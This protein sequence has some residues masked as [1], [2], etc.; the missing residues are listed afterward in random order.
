MKRT[1]FVL[2]VMGALVCAQE[3]GVPKGVLET[4]GNVSNIELT[5]YLVSGL[6]NP[7][8]ATKDEVPPD[9]NSMLQ[10]LHGVFMYKNYKLVDE[11]TLRSRNN[12][13]A[14]LGGEID[15]I[16]RGQYDFRYKFARVYPGEHVVHIDGLR[17]EISQRSLAPNLAPATVAL[18]ATDL[19]VADGQK[20]VV[21]KSAHNGDGLFLV[22]VPKIIP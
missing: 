13:G 1:A 7:P 6:A 14:E 4:K 11:F 18:V 8:A 15:Y 3:K 20:T 17:L 12:G 10:Q 21:G 2:L 22:V 5:V 16:P 9:L 19:D